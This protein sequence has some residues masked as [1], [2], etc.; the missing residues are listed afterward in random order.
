[1]NQKKHLLWLT[2]DQALPDLSKDAVIDSPIEGLIAAG[3]ELSVARLLE[4]YG[5][6]M[7]PWFSND[8]PVLWWSPDPRMVLQ[9][10]DFKLHRSLRK[11]LQKFIRSVNHEIRF[12]T[13]FESVIGH[14][15]QQPRA[16]QSGTWIVQS[17]QQA[18]LALHRAGHAHSVETWQDGR[19]VGGLY[20]VNI[21]RC[22]F[23][24]SMFSLTTDASKIA[25]SALVA[26]AKEQH[27]PWSDCQQHTQ[28]LASL[29]AKEVQR[30]AFIQSIQATQSAPRPAW[31]FRP[32]YW[33]HLLPD[34][35]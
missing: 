20:C 14:C 9:T 31:E 7:F 23:G 15:A 35:A 34:F 19:L 12:D 8:Q 33:K 27:I 18:Y 30:A 1:M 26:F 25:L 17:M 4:A 13:S 24:E 10:A 28:H 6:G 22:V 21:G 5:K 32:I 2:T 29:G 3:G 11:T 16:G